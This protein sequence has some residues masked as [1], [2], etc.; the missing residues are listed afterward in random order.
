M[1]PMP[2]AM[3]MS[4][5]RW[6]S[7]CRK[8]S[9]VSRSNMVKRTS[10]HFKC[11]I[12]CAASM[13][14]RNTFWPAAVSSSRSWTCLLSCVF[15][16]SA[17][18]MPAKKMP[19]TTRT[20]VAMESI[21]TSAAQQLFWSLELPI[22]QRFFWGPWNLHRKSASKMSQNTLAGLAAPSSPGW[23]CASPDY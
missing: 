1:T 12:T 3:F 18:T 10:K 23:S 4:C 13:A 20:F 14:K 8:T 16:S 21:L 11:F 15:S 17:A 5:E 19:G 6:P 22:P 9:C 2:V 7:H